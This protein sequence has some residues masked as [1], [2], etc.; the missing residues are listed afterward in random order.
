MLWTKGTIGSEALV[1]K[2]CGRAFP[3]SDV[4]DLTIFECVLPCVV[5]MV[6]QKLAGA[7]ESMAGT[8]DA[9]FGWH[10]LEEPQR[11]LFPM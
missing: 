10:S 4:C 7:D 2:M 5:T 1:V 11:C 6:M 9:A 3:G 8:T